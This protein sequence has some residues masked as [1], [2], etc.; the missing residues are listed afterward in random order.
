M[1]MVLIAALYI[2]L[3]SVYFYQ[4]RFNLSVFIFYLYSLK[5]FN[6]TLIYEYS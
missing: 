2:V 5:F 1:H 6:I 4:N 3:Y